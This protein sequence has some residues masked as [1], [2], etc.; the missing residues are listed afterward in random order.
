LNL[1]KLGRENLDN[2]IICQAINNNQSATVSSSIKVDIA[3]PPLNVK[4]LRREHAL[5]AGQSRTIECE[6]KG[7][8]PTP[9]ITWWKDRIHLEES[10]SR[11]FLDGNTTI[12]SIQIRPNREDGGKILTCRA[13]TPGIAKVLEDHWELP[14]HYLPQSRIKLGGSLDS[15]NIQEFDDVCFECKVKAIPSYRHIQWRHNGKIIQQAKSSGI[16][17]SGNSLAIQGIQ[18]H[19]GGN[20][21][22][23]A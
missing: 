10:H 8:R 12:S 14:V 15:K 13:Q 9:S 3:L 6:V 20:Y 17:I 1:K 19:S 7:A 23:A 2:L 5:I 18:R 4:I 11:T 21:S 22:C 16:I